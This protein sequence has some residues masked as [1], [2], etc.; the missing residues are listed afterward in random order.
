MDNKKLLKL[1]TD[2]IVY[3]LL[4]I[5]IFV[6]GI[7]LLVPKVKSVISN[8]QVLKEK[9]ENMTNLQRELDALKETIQKKKQQ[10]NEEEKQQK[11]KKNLEKPFFKTHISGSDSFSTNAPLFEDIIKIL[12]ANKLKLVSVE[13]KVSGFDDEIT[14]NNGSQVSSCLINMQL[15]GSYGHFQKFLTYLYDYP[16][17]IKIDS[18]E[19]IPFDKDKS[20]LIINLS[21][22][23]YSEFS[24]SDNV[25][26]QATN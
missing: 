4:I 19:T 21:L 16:Y 5:V 7:Y 20:T 24:D 23:L 3:F 2:N 8:R 10:E 26:D 11:E 6:G 9:E 13:N 25:I 14:Q 18:I 1:I 17:F 22:I 12:K 15:L